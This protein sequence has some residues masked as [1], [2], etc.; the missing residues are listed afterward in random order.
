MAH[1]AELND[2]NIV[3]RVVVIDNDEIK[4]GDGNESEA[5][6][7]TVCQSYFNGG[8]WVQTSY[9]NN[10][11]GLYA[12]IG[13]TYDAFRDIF[14]PVQEFPSWSFN[15]GTF[16]WEAPVALPADDGENADK[17]QFV[18]YKWNEDLQQWGDRNVMD[19]PVS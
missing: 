9:N 16:K 15:V 1:F 4:D 3:L 14:I 12:G 17:T 11:R 19:I 10:I 8:T 18:S 13:Y 7:I 5:V 2:N 6:G